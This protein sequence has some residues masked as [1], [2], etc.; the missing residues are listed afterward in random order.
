[1]KS[2]SVPIE[3]KRFAG[4]ISDSLKETANGQIAD[5]FFFSRALNYR[6]DPQSL[7]LLPGALKE[8]GSVVIDLLKWGDINPVDLT[9]YYYGDA[10]T[11]YSRTPSATWTNL[12]TVPQSHGNGLAY[13]AGD[14]NLYFTSDSTIGKY[15]PLS[16]SP[17]F[18]ND[19]LGAEGGVPLNTASVVLVSA[20]Q[21]YAHAADSATLSI[22]GDITL[23]TFFKANSLPAVGSSMTLVGKWDESGATRSYIMDLLGVS[24]Y[25][26]NASDGNLTISSNTTEAP[27]DSICSGTAGSTTL[28]A[29]NASFAAG[30]V[31]KIYQSQGTSA[32]QAERNIVQSYISG[33]ITL[34]TPLLGTYTTGAQVR[35]L[36]QYGSVTVNT[37]I[38][39]SAKAWNGATGGILGYLSSG[40][41][42]PAGTIS[43]SG[44]GFSLNGVGGVSMG[45]QG[46]GTAG[47]GSMSRVANG[48]GGGA[49]T[50]F[51]NMSPAGGGNGT[52][53]TNGNNSIGGNQSQGGFISGSTDLTSLTFGGQGGGASAGGGPGVPGGRGGNGG[54]IIDITAVSIPTITGSIVSAGDPG[55]TNGGYG[56]GGGAGGSILIKAQVVDLG[57]LKVTAP[58]GA[59]GAGGPGAGRGADGRIAVN[60]LTSFTGTT[61]P[62]VTA[63]QDNTLV[64]TT[65][66]QARLGISNN[67]SSTEY[68]TKNIATFTTG[69]WNRLSISW[70]ASA[71]MASFYLNAVPF[72]TTVGTKT[73][74]SDNTSLLYVGADKT[75]VIANYFDGELN[76]MRIWNNLQTADQIFNNNTVQVSPSSAG[77]AAYYKFNNSLADATA[78]ANNLTGVNTPTYTPDVPFSSP[79]TRLDIDQSY[80]VGGSTYA[81]PT[82][83]SEATVDTLPFT[84]MVDPQKS[85]AFDIS[86][87]GT[88]DLTVVIHDQQN[89]VIAQ[90]T[91]INA[92]VVGSGSQEFVYPTPW[93]RIA[94]RSYHAHLFSTQNDTVIVSSSVNDFA[95]ADFYTYFAFLIT[96]TQFHP[97]VQFQYQPLG[98]TL[99]QAL[100]IGNDNYLAVWDGA[101]YDPNFIQFPATWRVRCFGFW[102]EFLAIGMW[103]GGNI[104]DFDQGRI[105]FWDGVAPTFNFFVDVPEGQINALKGVDAD[106]YMFAGYRGQLL[107]YQGGYIQA[108]GATRSNKLKRMPLLASA[109]YTEVFPGAITMWRS[110]LHVGLMA[111]SNSTTMQ[112]GVYSWGTLF[113]FYPETLSYDYVISTGNTSSNVKIGLTYPV[114]KNLIVGWQDGIAFG[115]DVISFDNPCASTGEMQ[116]LA[117]D[118]G[119]IWHNNAQFQA[120]AD[121]LPLSTGQS[122]TPKVKLNRASTFTTGPVYATPDERTFAKVQIPTGRANEY[123]I[124]VDITSSSGVSPTIQALSIQQNPLSQEQTY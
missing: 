18:V 32:G 12:S 98:G 82:A 68:L 1:M 11:I 69:M 113:P 8:S 52:V 95:T 116:T 75:T 67:G 23:E 60:Y 72:G 124:G 73:S 54:G 37:G 33:T 2:S 27:I 65:T 64:T 119:T 22:T 77:L 10:G 15:G 55:V 105:Y 120:R 88:G 71:S 122:I 43:A 51:Q 70:D 38:T 24:G 49:G 3:Q 62:T 41:F 81:V 50:D 20:S 16:G 102:R 106:L 114:G 118:D 121:F 109:D 90:S 86:T 57:T 96:D 47:T 58:G 79:T 6:D 28:S 48:N 87:K 59:P 63:V 117:M 66:V 80:L 115:A 30:Q 76:D 29:T 93:T 78:N 45:Q 34:G 107:D 7:T 103:R 111:N 39:Y 46:E 123:M 61:S 94:G 35:V 99:S 110:L 85:I 31:I 13:F 104:Y 4:G 44:K 9:T 112:R 74:I 53:G 21:Q 108:N 19:F 101:N 5:S 97:I 42:T 26:G 40:T 100:I 25:F 17:Q 91:V 84:P 83:L 56:A 36:K 14:D 89:N 92:N